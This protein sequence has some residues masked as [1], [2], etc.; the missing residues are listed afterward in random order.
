MRVDVFRFATKLGHCSVQSALRICA[1][2]GHA[3]RRP[4]VQKWISFGVGSVVIVRVFDGYS[5]FASE[6]NERNAK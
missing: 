2:F 1:K 4:F 5:N 6:T 3:S